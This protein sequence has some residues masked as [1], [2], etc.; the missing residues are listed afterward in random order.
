MEE[1]TIVFTYHKGWDDIITEEVEFPIDA[2]EEEIQEVF[3]YW[4]W[5]K[6]GDKVSWS[7]K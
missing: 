2:D 5:D 4:V 6:I 7:E 3:E 1:K